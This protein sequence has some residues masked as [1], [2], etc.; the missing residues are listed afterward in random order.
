M[1]YARTALVS[2]DSQILSSFVRGGGHD[3]PRSELIAVHERGLLG[4]AT[5]DTAK[6]LYCLH[7]GVLQAGGDLRIT[8]LNRSSAIQLT[9]RRKYENWLDADEPRP[10]TPGWNADTMKNAFVALPGR[11]FHNGGRAIDIY[12]DVLSFPSTPADQQLDVFW[13]VAQPL[14]WRPII[15]KPT[16]GAKESW[17]FDFMG[18]WLPVYKRRGYAEAAMCAALDIGAWDAIAR[19]EWRFV[20]AQLHRAGYACGEVDGWP[21]ATNDSK[22]RRALRAAGL[23]FGASNP[24]QLFEAASALM[25][26]SKTLWRP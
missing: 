26:S 9:A 8:D 11:S 2:V 5:P 22:T 18:E 13:S 4:M 3:G 10:G 6:A 12:V 20:Q 23:D 1:T 25:S 14:G 15:G 17:H 16:E 21:G 19:P 7:L 24:E